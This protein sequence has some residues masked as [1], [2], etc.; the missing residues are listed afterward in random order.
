MLNKHIAFRS[1]MRSDAVAAQSLS[2]VEAYQ[3]HA[4]LATEIAEVLRKN[5][6]QAARVA[7]TSEDGAEKETWS[8]LRRYIYSY[9]SLTDDIQDY[10]SQKTLSWDRTKP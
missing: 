1:K 3:Q 9:S 4:K 8:E 5:I 10:E 6:V 7:E 2:D